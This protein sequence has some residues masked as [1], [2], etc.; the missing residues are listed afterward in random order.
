MPAKK[1]NDTL[2][3]IKKS[4]RMAPWAVSLV[5]AALPGFGQ[6]Y[7]QSYWKLPILYGL[8]GWFGYNIVQQNN[9]YITYRDLYSQDQTG[10]TSSSNRSFR[11]YYKKSR[12]EFIIFLALT[13]LGGIVDAYVDAH[14]YDFDVSEDLSNY[15]SPKTESIQLVSFKIKF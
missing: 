3:V 7:N 5:S 10:A 2:T 9:K 11:E 13:Y 15:S 1:T 14:L 12:N 6:V 4:N 8:M